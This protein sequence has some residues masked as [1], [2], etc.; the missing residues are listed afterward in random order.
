MVRE[1][2]GYD[3]HPKRAHRATSLILF[4]FSMVERKGKVFSSIRLDNLN[5]NLCYELVPPDRIGRDLR[6]GDSLYNQTVTTLLCWAQC[7]CSPSEPHI[8]ADSPCDISD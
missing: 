3:P 8:Y 4:M 6:E 5:V 1:G 2:G 7:V